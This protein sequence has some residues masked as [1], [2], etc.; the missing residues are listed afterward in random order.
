MRSLRAV[1]RSLLAAAALAPA[2]ALAGPPLLRHLPGARP[3]V[4]S[5]V[6]TSPQG[7]KVFLDVV[8]VPEDLQAAVD[9]P[10]SVFLATHKHGDH[11]AGT[12]A[13]RFKGKKLVQAAGTIESGDVKVEAITSSHL[14]DELDGSD[15]IMVVDVAG[16]RIAHFG[17]CG[18]DALTKE[19]L[20]RLGRVDVMIHSFENVFADADVLNKK[21][22]LVVAQVKP[23]LVI[24]THIVSA[25]AV[26]LLAETHP[27]ASVPRN[28]LALTPELLA[29][30][31]RSLYMGGN[32]ELAAQAGVPPA[33]DL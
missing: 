10:R 25:A 24:P 11:Y 9:D 6:V 22:F 3:T 27:A 19:Q 13:Q 31:K 7:V 5:F 14:D 1:L 8:S 17:D 20:A 23:T 32:A 29:G 26:K 15:V 12:S 21:A 16:V 18:Q 30:G 4:N 33:K 28:E 2:F